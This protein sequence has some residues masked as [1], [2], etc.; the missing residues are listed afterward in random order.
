MG[1][2]RTKTAIKKGWENIPKTAEKY[3][4]RFKYTKEVI[5]QNCGMKV[6]KKQ[7]FCDITCKDKYYNKIM[8]LKKE[9]ERI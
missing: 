6:E 8:E 9:S 4:R 7:R 3:G 2:R 1:T 5:C